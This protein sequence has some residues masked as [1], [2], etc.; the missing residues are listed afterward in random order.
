MS[1]W[2]AL[3]NLMVAVAAFLAGYVFGR[4]RRIAPP[5]DVHE[6]FARNLDRAASDPEFVDWYKLRMKSPTELT[7]SEIQR[8]HAEGLEWNPRAACWTPAVL[9]NRASRP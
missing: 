3:F 2:Q 5:L 4:V 1:V 9:V 8:F 6:A 7:M